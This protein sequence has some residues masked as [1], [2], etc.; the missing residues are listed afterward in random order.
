MGKAL[1]LLAAIL[2]GLGL[3]MTFSNVFDTYK[4][5]HLN[6]I[7]PLTDN[8][9]PYVD[10]LGGSVP[11]YNSFDHLIVYNLPYLLYVGAA[12]CVVIGLGKMRS[13]EE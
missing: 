9:T 1:L 6:L 11:T 7:K 10:S 2:V 8:V 13:S 3:L 12:V 5:I 4:D